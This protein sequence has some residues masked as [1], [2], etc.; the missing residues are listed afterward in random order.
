MDWGTFQKYFCDPD[1]E[2]CYARIATLL[3]YTMM[4]RT[5]KTSIL[6]RPIITLPPPHPNIVYIQFS[7]EEKIIYRITE[8][9]FRSNLN[10][11]FRKGEARSNYSAFMV[12][13]LRLRQCTSHPFMLEKTIKE[14]WTYEDVNELRTRLEGIKG[15]LKRPFYTQCHLWVEKSEAE[16]QAARDR[17]EE[18]LPFGKGD[19]GHKFSFDKALSSL[20]DEQLFARVTC[21]LCSDL[22]A[23]PVKTDVSL[24]CHT[25]IFPVSMLDIQSWLQMYKANRI[26]LI[27]WTHLLQR[28][29]RR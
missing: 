4:R 17:G 28:L 7:Q 12:Q 10:A 24:H 3:S 15:G 22:P 14:S 8:N 13:L 19:Y 16:R 25:S 5:M 21:S 11:F 6:N 26:P 27:V 23:S 20:S 9:R 18:M 2:D 29:P 1:A